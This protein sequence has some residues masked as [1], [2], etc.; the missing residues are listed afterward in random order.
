MSI[1]LD[2]LCE[3]C[4]SEFVLRYDE[5]QVIEHEKLT[6]PFC[7]EVLDTHVDEFDQ[8]DPSD[9]DFLED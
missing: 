9:E 1:N 2:A 7:K 3:N 8:Y 4:D 6:C 5:H